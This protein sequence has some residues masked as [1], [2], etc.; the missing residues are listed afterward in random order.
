MTDFARRTASRSSE[1]KQLALLAV[2]A[3]LS[4]CARSGEADQRL[5]GVW[6]IST[7]IIQGV[8]HT[9]RGL[10]DITPKYFL[11]D[12][13]FDFDDDAHLSANANSGPYQVKNGKII[14]QQEMQLHWRPG[15]RENENFLHQNVQ[16]T[17]AYR[18]ENGTLLF[19]FPSGN[20]YVL[21]RAP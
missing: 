6:R 18:F 21:E 19:L 20:R 2:L 14:L 11:A 13:V 10:V 9:A 7:Y 3:M 5:Y 15:Q 17:F 12:A 1:R 8:S 16:E 4:T